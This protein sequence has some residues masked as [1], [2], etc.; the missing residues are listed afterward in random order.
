MSDDSNEITVADIEDGARIELESGWSVVVRVETDMDA[1]PP[2]KEA[3]GHGEV[4]DWRP[5]NSKRAGE[6]VLCGDG[7]GGLGTDHSVWFYDFAGA[8]ATAR[9]DR[10]VCSHGIQR[11]TCGVIGIELC[12]EVLAGDACPHAQPNGHP[13]ARAMAACVAEQD[14]NF[15]RRWCNGDWEYISVTVTLYDAEGEEAGSDSLGG[16]ESDGDY[17]KQCAVEMIDG[18]TAGVA[19]PVAEVAQ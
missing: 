15:L 4:S 18:L 7:R 10:W 1:M 17:W 12:A 11:E 5:A 6:R 2:W 14:F 3:D 9:K 16:I 13:T 19:A 8:V